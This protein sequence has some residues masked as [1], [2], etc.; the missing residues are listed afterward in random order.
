MTDKE[1]AIGLMEE[2]DEYTKRLIFF[3]TLKK[4]RDPIAKASIPKESIAKL[5]LSPQLSP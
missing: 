4:K 5:S 2:I 3:W 1:R